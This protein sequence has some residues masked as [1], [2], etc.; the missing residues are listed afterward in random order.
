MKP[1]RSCQSQMRWKGFAISSNAPQPIFSDFKERIM[2]QAHNTI[3]YR[4]TPPHKQYSLL[5]VF[6]I[7]AG[8][9]FFCGVCAF[10]VFQW[11]F[12]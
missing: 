12:A 7:T 6:R 5:T 9:G 3:E 8:A 2:H 1:A 10:G 4:G 11:I